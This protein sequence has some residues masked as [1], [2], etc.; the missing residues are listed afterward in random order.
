MATDTSSTQLVV[1]GSSAGGIEAL[2]TFVSTL[3]RDFPAPIV[4]AQHLDPKRPSHLGEILERR[5]TAPVNTVLDNEEL[6]Q[7]AVYVIPSD[8]NVV[9]ADGHIKLQSDGDVR[10][11]PSIN[12]LF[13]SAAEVYGEALI[14][15][16]LTGT[17]SDGAAGALE[18]KKAGGTVVIQNPATATYPSMPQSLAPTAVDFIANVEEIGQLLYDL[19]TGASA[20]TQASETK[21][22]RTFL[23]DVHEFS[24][25]DFTTYKP[26]TILRRLKR[27]M[28]ATNSP[29]LDGYLRYLERQPE[30]YQR[31]I[32]T[33]LIKVTE[34]FRDR[35][36]FETLRR[37]TLPRLIED[38]RAGSK[39]LR[40]WSAGCATG[41][42]AYSIAVLVADAL[43]DELNQ[44][45]VRIFATDLDAQAIAFA[46]RGIYSRAAL[47]S[48]PPELVDRYFSQ[49]DGDF[50]VQK[51]VRGLVVFGQHDLGRRA[52]FPHMDLVLC[53]NVLIYFA[54]D[55]QKRVLQLFAY[56]LRTGG[57]LVLG[58]AETTSPLPDFF[59]PINS[60]LHIYRRY[61]EPLL[62]PK[63][64]ASIDPLPIQSAPS[65]GQ[66]ANPGTRAHFTPPAARPRTSFERLG[67]AVLN[68]P[69]GIAIID[70][71]YDVL[72]INPAA[73]RLLGIHRSAVGEDLLHLA[74]DVPQKPL[75]RIIDAG[76]R[77]LSERDMQATLE[78]GGDP[79]VAHRVHIRVF[80]QAPPHEGGAIESIAM[81]IIPVAA[82]EPN[83][84]LADSPEAQA[85]QAGA[86][87]Q[88]GVAGQQG[89]Q[90]EQARIADLEQQIQALTVVNR[91]YLDANEDLAQANLTLRQSNE[92]FLVTTEEL[93]AASEEV[94]TL[95]EELQASNEELETLNEEMQATVEELNTANDDLESRSHELQRAAFS[96]EEQRRTTETEREWLAAILAN[97]GDAVLVIDALGATV[98]TN[99]AYAQ[100]F[101]G[102]D[103]DFDPED[104]HGHPLTQEN[105]PHGRTLRGISGVTEFALTDADDN[106]REFEANGQPLR[107]GDTIT[108]GVI[109]IRDVTARNRLQSEF[110]ARAAH[111][112]RTPL[113]SAQAALQLLISRGMGESQPL[114]ERYLTIAHAQVK[115][116]G[117]LISDLVDVALLQSGKL[118]LQVIAVDLAVIAR[119]AVEALEPTIT[120]RIDLDIESEPLI[121]QGDA[122]R[123]EQVIHNLLMN[124][125]KYAPVSE[126]ID[127][128]L[129]RW[130]DEAEI[131][132]Q[133][134]GP[135]ITQIDTARLFTRF[136]QANRPDNATHGGLGLGLFIVRQIVLAHDGEVD[137]HSIP[138]DGATF[139]VRLPLSDV[140]D[141]AA[142]G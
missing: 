86:R 51:R 66:S 19:L 131:T 97:I 137:V 140:T 84:A 10:P 103:V 90:T 129:R 105:T 122:L 29:S 52:P 61:G 72:T 139:S 73:L 25:L 7:G 47:A 59:S 119:S 67:D 22:L 32:S 37:E 71:R 31:L 111:E 85:A 102:A 16:I 39:E 83:P 40:I 42:E 57:V 54:S 92:E 64:A 8:R 38:A 128:R 109:I 43:G 120:Q 99:A 80:P 136:Y 27:R 113:T 1:V 116:L 112:L 94:E 36:L 5:S 53:R 74:E 28:V 33:F 142:G 34:F 87:K 75:R 95:N 114:A 9:I 12:R 56:S 62:L 18:V 24:G 135:G 11:K 138:G 88:K 91:Q 63:G 115:R 78:V 14:A 81:Q 60:L 41:E 20:V 69:V 50:E 65:M 13:S 82:T 4:I 101:G 126:A 15:V 17:G 46:R 127:V 48:A 107:S 76:F 70:R 35:E 118:D 30:E 58:K 89:N 104:L 106:Q 141:Q 125:A 79:E 44:F 121:V 55:L 117:A 100:M 132:V 6:V 49:L 110:L 68:L 93:Q 133:D 134:R 123:L 124:S 77:N 108:G 98:Q 26:A 2:Q 23:N 130:G 3:P 21:L 96:L 45:T